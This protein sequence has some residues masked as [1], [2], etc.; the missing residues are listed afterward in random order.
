VLLEALPG[1]HI[2]A[3]SRHRLR[4][5]GETIHALEPLHPGYAAELFAV[6][7][8]AIRP[9]IVVGDEIGTLLPMLEGLPLAI[10]LAAAGCRA[11]DVA[12]VR[13]RLVARASL[14]PGPRDLP[15]RQR[16]LEANL[17]WST[18]LLEPA[19]R[20]LL[21]E[22]ATFEAPFDLAMVHAVSESGEDAAELLAELV[23]SSLVVPEGGRYRMLTSV[24]EFA[25]AA[26]D[27]VGQIVAD[28]HAAWTS[29]TVAACMER[30]RVGDEAVALSDLGRLFPDLRSSIDHLDARG[31]HEDAAR[32]LLAPMI[33]WYHFGL[34]DEVSRRLGSVAAQ[35]GLQP[36]TRAEALMMAAIIAKMM[37]T[38]PD[39]RTTL[40]ARISTLRPLADDSTHLAN[41]LCHLAAIEAE[42]GLSER[43]F[44][45]AE[46]AVRVARRGP[47]P[48]LVAMALDLSGYVAR[49]LGDAD[50]AVVAQEA[51]VALAR[52]IGSSQLINA[53]AGLAAVL[54]QAGRQ[55]EALD[56]AWEA[57]ALAERD[58][59][60]TQQAEVATTVGTVLGTADPGEA[61]ARLAAAVATWIAN[62]G[63]S[64]ALDA[65][66]LLAELA[67]TADVAG[68]TRLLAGLSAAAPGRA[69]QAGA[70]QEVLRSSLGDSAFARERAAGMVLDG[71]ALGR[72]AADLAS[73]VRSGATA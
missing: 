10:E 55:R 6:R 57:I 20:M 47:D 12:D 40:D 52:E 11:L 67:A 3:T 28:R 26:G 66:V 71:D 56:A 5:A 29:A 49:V 72:L 4:L 45:H 1:V 22:L 50:R 54:G 62:G 46:E 39:A 31:R 41:G 21:I 65:G 70:L 69:S 33:A 24:R 2:L 18:D 53:L 16:S 25:R 35:D 15:E 51:A 73:A 8:R 63:R 58:G 36:R 59:T 19:T 9:D 60:P 23:E 43:A 37:G 38:D 7:G 68:A 32:L 13:A 34:L 44:A 14:P 48:G 42:A 27:D 30:V 64:T 17:A 61:A